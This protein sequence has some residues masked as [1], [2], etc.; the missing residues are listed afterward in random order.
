MKQTV[1]GWNT[2]L[3]A[4]SSSLPWLHLDAP[5]I[6]ISTPLFFT[7]VFG[8]LFGPL[9]CLSRSLSGKIRYGYV[10]DLLLVTLYAA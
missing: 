5:L 2:Q 8:V 1:I 9:F 3:F 4:S 7:L 6:S 10:A